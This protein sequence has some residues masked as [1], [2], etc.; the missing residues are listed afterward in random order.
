MRPFLSFPSFPGVK[1]SFKSTHCGNPTSSWKPTSRRR[2]VN[3]HAK[4][5]AE[6]D[7]GAGPL[8][9]RPAL[10]VG[11]APDPTRREEGVAFTTRHPVPL[12]QAGG[13]VFRKHNP[14]SVMCARG[15]NTSNLDPLTP[16]HAE[17]PSRA[18]GAQSGRGSTQLLAGPV[19][20]SRGEQRPLTQSTG[21]PTAR[22]TVTKGPRSMKSLAIGRPLSP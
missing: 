17:R 9:A 5:G 21:A 10:K 20:V 7:R 13:T 16:Q 22:E 15:K 8:A 2:G 12:R 3:R 11:V 14:G 6:K 18:H 4:D 19:R 1:V